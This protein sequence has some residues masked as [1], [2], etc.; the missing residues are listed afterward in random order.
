MTII[1]WTKKM[2]IGINPYIWVKVFFVYIKTC[3]VRVVFI[4]LKLYQDRVFIIIIDIL[5]FIVPL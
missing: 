4:G 2:K 5:H 3:L 1:K